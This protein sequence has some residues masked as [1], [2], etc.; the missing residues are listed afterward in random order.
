MST[1]LT[2]LAADL[3]ARGYTAAS[4]PQAVA[5]TLNGLTVT[6]VVP[7]AFVRLRT[8]DNL[9]VDPVAC[10]AVIDGLAGAAATLA[11][12]S[13]APTA[14]MGKRLHRAVGYMAGTGDTD[15]IDV[16][17]PSVRTMID[18]LAMQEVLTAAAA[19]TIKAYGTSTVGYVQAT[20]GVPALTADDVVAAWGA[21]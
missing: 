13:D 7:G 3:T 9:F 19:A 2:N 11:A 1:L 20:Y 5:T 10:Q 6:T 12:S 17:D 18:Q 14:A 21:K 16:G 8:L 4:D 15:G